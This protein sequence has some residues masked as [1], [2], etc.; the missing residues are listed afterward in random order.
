MPLIFSPEQCRAARGL[1]NWS[2]RE[3]AERSGVSKKTIADFELGERTPYPRTLADIVRTFEAAGVEFTNGD[4]PG[5]K[6]HR[7][8]A[9]ARNGET[10]HDAPPLAKPPRPR[11]GE[12]A[13]IDLED[14]IAARAPRHVAGKGVIAA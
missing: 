4:A 14:V 2:Q 9:A 3:F 5:V 12:D 1:L 11:K 6:L 10:D 7:T 8:C 13:Q